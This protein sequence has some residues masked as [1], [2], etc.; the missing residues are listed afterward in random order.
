MIWIKE[1]TQILLLVSIYLW[2]KETADV[3]LIQQTNSIFLTYT[4]RYSHNDVCLDQAVY[5]TEKAIITTPQKLTN[6]CK[7]LGSFCF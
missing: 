5:E 1:S 2:L 4:R 7:K 6:F 3:Y